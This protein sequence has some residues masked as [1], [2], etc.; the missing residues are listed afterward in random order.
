[1]LRFLFFVRN[2]H[3]SVVLTLWSRSWLIYFLGG[4]DFTFTCFGIYI[5]LFFSFE[6]ILHFYDIIN[7]VLSYDLTSAKCPFSCVYVCDVLNRTGANFVMVA[8][9]LKTFVTR[10]LLLIHFQ[11]CVCALLFFFLFLFFYGMLLLSVYHLLDNDR[12]TVETSCF[13]VG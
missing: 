5:L 1:M 4:E 7:G 2:M 13:N 11:L 8:L 9:V 6:L 12:G 10:L 3:A